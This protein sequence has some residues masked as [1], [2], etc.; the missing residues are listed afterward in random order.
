MTTPR[1]HVYHSIR[2]FDRSGMVVATL[3]STSRVSLM[4]QFDRDYGARDFS[5]QW[6]SD[7]EAKELVRVAPRPTDDD[8]R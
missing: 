1:G 8:T 4:E 5:Y 6:M 7:E 2:V 3:A